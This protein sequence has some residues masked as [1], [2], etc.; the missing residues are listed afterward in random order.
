MGQG[1][2]YLTTIES[3]WFVEPRVGYFWAPLC[4]LVPRFGQL[5]ML[6][7]NKGKDYDHQTLVMSFY[8]KPY[9]VGVSHRL[10]SEISQV[11]RLLTSLCFKWSIDMHLYMYIIRIAARFMTHVSLCVQMPLRFVSRL[12]RFRPYILYSRLYYGEHRVTC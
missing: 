12:V 3:A 2:I 11:V 7:L 1:I 9:Q 5:R 8:T 10:F 6:T 4:V